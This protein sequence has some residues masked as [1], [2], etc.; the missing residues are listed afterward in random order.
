MRK[1]KSLATGSIIGLKITR[2]D[3]SVE[4]H[5]DA[6]AQALYGASIWRIEITRTGESIGWEDILQTIAKQDPSPVV[7]VEI[8]GWE[9]RRAR[10]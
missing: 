4:H 2:A 3:G 6:N 10:D 5:G 9:A 8:V 7:A 1:G